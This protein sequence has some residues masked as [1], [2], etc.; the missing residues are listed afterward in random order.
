MSS[1]ASRVETQLQFPPVADLKV[2]PEPEYP[3]AALAPGPAGA[4]AER[5][6]HDDMLAWGRKGWAQN[7]RVCGWAVELGLK[8]PKGYCNPAAR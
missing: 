5:K 4:E 8:V 6:W 3:V 7:A 2:E 1:C